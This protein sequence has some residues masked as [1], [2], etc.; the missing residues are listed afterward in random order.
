MV[1]F[2]KF[3]VDAAG[4]LNDISKGAFDT[5]GLKHQG[6]V[7]PGFGKLLEGSFADGAKSILAKAGFSSDQLQTWGTTG[8]QET[9][10]Q[11]SG[12][13]GSELAATA[14]GAAVGGPAGVVFGFGVETGQILSGI[15]RDTGPFSSN[16]SYS[17]GQ[18]IAVDN[19]L[20]A[21]THG[22]RDALDHIDEVDRRRLGAG[23]NFGPHVDP[24][25]GLE[26]REN[27]SIGFVLGP[28]ED[29]DTVHIFNLGK[30]REETKRMGHVRPL[31]TPQ[32][33]AMDQN[34]VWSEIRLLRFEADLSEQLD[35]TVCTD[36]GAEVVHDGEYFMVVQANGRNVQVEHKRTHAQ[37]WTT[38]DELQ[39]GRRNHNNTWN[40]QRGEVQ[41]SFTAGEKAPLAVGDWV[42]LRPS[43]DV[44][45]VFPSVEKQLAC[46]RQLSGA[47]VDLHYAVD[48]AAVRVSSADSGLRPVSDE[49]N[50]YL[51]SSRIFAQFKD[52]AVRGAETERLAA[53]RHRSATLLC[54]GVS[55]LDEATEKRADWRQN[56]HKRWHEK[57]EAQ[58]HIRIAA[59]RVTVGDGG[60]AEKLDA[61]EELGV[62]AGLPHQ[63]AL[64]AAL[65]PVDPDA[66]PT[67]AGG[68]S[69]F[70]V[71]GLAGAGA[72][73]FFLR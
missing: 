5:F 32:A 54:L 67:P 46:V 13:V 49:I 9:L 27:L 62:L 43:A 70:A 19:G 10:K 12:A 73:L 8:W 15:F 14:A 41:G 65:E 26:M 44:A 52:A 3:I 29:P 59:Q 24:G 30:S 39:P 38:V 37:H 47:M 68:T 7:D 64:E 18:W 71:L 69:P 35:T 36:P 17:P 11:V 16:V 48:G 21:V 60:L 63:D 4:K 58:R 1:Q 56:L 20:T 33:T 61:A 57:R 45:R 2:G 23:V 53:G 40:Y 72:A 25:E 34:P 55:P 51:G 22:F 50:A 6:R 28:G 66:D 31:D 42:W